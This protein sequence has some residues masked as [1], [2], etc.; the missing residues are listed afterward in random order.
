[1]AFAYPASMA[2]LKPDESAREGLRILGGCVLAAVC[3]G[4][5]LDLVT[6]VF[7]P[8]Y[9]SFF[10]PPLGR[11]HNPLLLAFAWGIL[12]SWW[13]GVAGSLPVMAVAGI[14][15]RPPATWKGIAPELLV[16]LGVSFLLANLVGLAGYLYPEG[17]GSSMIGGFAGMADFTPHVFDDRGFIAMYV[18]HAVSYRLAAIA[19]I[20]LL[21]RIPAKRRIGP[22]RPGDL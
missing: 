5:A 13:V 18:Q 2:R 6:I 19:C 12:G 11:L 20:V 17:V 4:I 9:L 1:M 7:Y 16:M 15:K 21:A 14:G 3:Y 8:S 22:S 10:H